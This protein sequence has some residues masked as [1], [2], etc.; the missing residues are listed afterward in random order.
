MKR[1]FL[2]ALV[3][4]ANFLVHCLGLAEEFSWAPIDSGVFAARPDTNWGPTHAF[5]LFRH[6]ILNHKKGFREVYVRTKIVDEEGYGAADVTVTYTKKRP[7]EWI[8]AR[9]IT[10][11]GVYPLGK[12]DFYFKAI[13]KKNLD[14]YECSFSFPHVE[15]GCIVEYAYRI[16]SQKVRPVSEN[17]IYVWKY[18]SSRPVQQAVLEWILAPK[19]W[20]QEAFYG[21]GEVRLVPVYVWGPKGNEGHTALSDDDKIVFVAENVSPLYEEPYAPS[22]DAIAP[23]LYLAYEDT[24]D[25][26]SK[27]RWLHFLTSESLE[28]FLSHGEHL[29]TLVEN[30]F[31]PIQDPNERAKVIYEWF[32]RNI[33]CTDYTQIKDRRP[34][35]SV[36]DLLDHGYGSVGEIKYATVLAMRKAGLSAHLAYLVDRDEGYLNPNL[37][38]WV[39]SRAIVFVRTPTGRSFFCYPGVPYLAFGELPWYCQWAKALVVEYGLVRQATIPG[40]TPEKNR[41]YRTL[42]LTV[43]D[44]DSVSGSIA[45]T[46]SG[47]F[48]LE[49]RQEMWGLEGDSLQVSLERWLGE[50]LRNG[51]MIGTITHARLDSVGRSIRLSG[52][53]GIAE[54]LRPIGTKLQIKPL[55]Y[56]KWSKNPFTSEER[57]YP[58]MFRSNHEIIESVTVHF[59]KGWKVVGVPSDDGIATRAGICRVQFART[60]DGGVNIQRAFRLVRPWFDVEEYDAVRELFEKNE[61]LSQLPVVVEKPLFH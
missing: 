27:W 14:L 23:R 31:K 7:I 55:L 26:Q 18:A 32:R 12:S 56:L 22:Q 11:N 21:F 29:A 24:S 57:H 9:T 34:N 54:R 37:P 47:Q 58:V 5:D 15:P 59:P 4:F 50:Q 6:V 3:L 38:Y 35:G 46:L 44:S 42:M 20:R 2:W 51:K 36:D 25:K 10:R 43:D 48:A 52:K 28:S 33:R 13:E 17:W 40:T 49:L 30:K 19:R 61:A 39:F 16:E 41:A 53:F 1:G 8:R 45:E 60:S